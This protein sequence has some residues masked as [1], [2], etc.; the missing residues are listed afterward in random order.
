MRVVLPGGTVDLPARVV[1]TPA[2][3]IPLREKEARLFE[4]L[5]THPGEVVSREQLYGEVFGYSANVVSRT[6]DTTIRRLRRKLAAAGADGLV[7]TVYGEG[8]RFLPPARSRTDRALVGY[9][10]AE[11][12]L[13]DALA[14][15]RVVV[16]TGPGG[17]GKTALAQEVL[18][19]G[20]DVC[21]VSCAGDRPLA[22]RVLEGLGMDT[23]PVE[24]MEAALALRTGLVLVL[25]DA[26]HL[27]AD[28]VAEAVGW[29]AS[30]LLVSRARLD[31]AGARSVEL[32]GLE[33][34]EAA[35]LFLRASG[36]SVA[37]EGLDALLELLDHQPLALLLAAHRVRTLGFALVAT[38]LTS[39]PDVLADAQAVDPR[40]GSLAQVLDAMIG[41]VSD[42]ARRALARMAVLEEPADG[43]LALAVGGAPGPLGDL[44]DAW[45]LVR[46]HDGF[47]MHPR[48]R[49]H[50]LHT[51]DPADVAEGEWLALACV[52]GRVRR[53]LP[54][55]VDL[56]ARGALERVVV[57]ARATRHPEA[58]VL[59][60]ALCLRQLDDLGDPAGLAPILA[61][62]DP[63]DPVCALVAVHLTREARATTDAEVA[64]ADRAVE[65]TRHDP[66]LLADALLQR[67]AV[68]SRKDDTEGCRAAL[69]AFER[70]ARTLG[71]DATLWAWVRC[72]AHL[73]PVD[74]AAAD[75]WAR[76]VEPHLD[77]LPLRERFRW[78]RI[79]IP[80]AG[81]RFEHTRAM[82]L[83]DAF[84]AL[85]EELGEAADR[86]QA[87]VLRAPTRWFAGDHDGSRADCERGVELSVAGPRWLQ[88]GAASNLAAHAF[89]ALDW[90]AA[91]RAAGLASLRAGSSERAQRAAELNLATLDRELGRGAP[92]V[93]GIQDVA[94]ER[95]MLWPAQCGDLETSV[96]LALDV[97][98]EGGELTWRRARYLAA[99]GEVLVAAGRW[100]EALA[101]L[102][103]AVTVRATSA[104]RPL[105]DT[106]QAVAERAL[107]RPSALRAHAGASA[108]QRLASGI[109][110]CVHRALDGDPEGAKA[111]L[112]TLEATLTSPLLT[113]RNVF[114]WRVASA[115]RWTT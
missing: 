81:H 98:G 57:R 61:E 92:D 20:R 53:T 74:I 3:G 19:G 55:L 39:R 76:R 62:L 93:G 11:R 94:D 112:D 80:I 35:G 111:H 34:S 86:A 91:A 63:G 41:L 18:Q 102:D 33:P 31:V 75:R 90:E 25:D 87:Y 49:A 108:Y 72:A 29:G 51:A 27:D 36:L 114:A 84:V 101:A 1:E 32:T 66:V 37:P 6:L 56:P 73:E 83:C 7:Q 40:H 48:V 4:V 22:R 21:M 28:Q 96:R 30:L 85:A 16:L 113:P 12:Q 5:A 10:E 106:L 60:Y 95:A 17:V 42:D 8:Y 115:R 89:D 38:H 52:A 9:E 88:F 68:L 104:E 71:E 109:W 110:G 46:R 65:R 100:E 97:L 2:G 24:G 70:H 77:R 69:E 105:L 26:E 82:A 58:P 103:E 45:L 43:E 54:T 64:I 44:V 59:L 50:V 23:A 99:A 14:T 79:T 78:Y 13:V 15:S 67:A 47:A 107:G